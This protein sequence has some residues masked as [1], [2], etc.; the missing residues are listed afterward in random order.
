[1]RLRML[2][3]QE[4]ATKTD[5]EE[6][7]LKSYRAVSSDLKKFA[8][9]FLKKK[10]IDWQGVKHEILKRMEERKIKELKEMNKK[11][12]EELKNMKT[13]PFED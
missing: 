1:M 12:E 4:L 11:M 9:N 2:F 6:D 3:E 7:S 13:K 8:R 10:K 5:E